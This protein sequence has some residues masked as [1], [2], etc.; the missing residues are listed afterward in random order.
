MKCPDCWEEGCKYV[1]P[2]VVKPFGKPSSDI[3]IKRVD[4]RAKCVRCG[5]SGI[6]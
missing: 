1:V 2:R 3:P 5:W 4:F 6:V